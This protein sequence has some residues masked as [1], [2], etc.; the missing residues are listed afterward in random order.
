MAV[1]CQKCGQKA[2][3]Y[4]TECSDCGT[5]LSVPN[6]PTYTSASVASMIFFFLPTGLIALLYSLKVNKKIIEGDL[7]SAI[8]YSKKALLF[9]WISFLFVVF[10]LVFHFATN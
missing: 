5:K 1:F 3:K 2:K 6:I 9:C 7:D 10:Y 8:K 4:K